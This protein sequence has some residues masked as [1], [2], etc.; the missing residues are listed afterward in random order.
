M[1]RRCRFFPREY[2]AEVVEL[3][4][5]SSKTIGQVTKELDLTENA[6]REWVTGGIRGSSPCPSPP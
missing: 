5:S 3:I 6:V 4:R 1:P 2:K